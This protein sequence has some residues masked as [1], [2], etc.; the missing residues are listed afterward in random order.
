MFNKTTAKL[1]PRIEKWV[2][3]MQDVD[4]ELVYEPGKDEADPLDFLSRHPLPETGTDSTEKMI[5]QVIEADHAVIIDRIRYETQHDKQLQKLHKRIRAEDWES[6]R[7]DPDITP[8]YSIRQELY[9]ADGLMFRLNRIVIPNCLQHKVIKAAHSLGHLGMTKT[10]QMLR[11]KYWFPM[12]NS[13]VEQIIGQCYECQ[14]TTKDHKQQPI[15]MTPIPEKPWEVIAVDFG[16]PYPDGHYNLVAV[17]KRTRYPEVKTT[18]STAFK[19]TMEKLKEM[20]AAHG[21]PRRLE[22]DNGPPFNSKEFTEF[23]K[24]E[25]LHHHKVTPDH[26]R[27]NGEA[28][29]FMKLLNRAEQ[30]AHLQK[31]NRNII[32]QEML[33]G[34]RSTPHPATNITP[35]EA[36][37]NR[38]VRTKLD[39]QPGKHTQNIKDSI[40]DEND[41]QYK[42]RL[43]QNAENRNTKQ[44]NFVVGDYVLLKQTKKNKWSTAYEPAFYIIYRIDNSSIAARRVT[45]GRDI[46]RDASHFKLVNSVVRNTDDVTMHQDDAESEDDWREGILLQSNPETQPDETSPTQP[47]LSSNKE[48]TSR[49]VFTPPE[50]KP[51]TQTSPEPHT[52]PRRNR[53]RPT[54]LR[55][56]VD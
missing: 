53:Q 8:F 17:D 13:M 24:R 55:D 40:I 48:S 33:T 20:F 12:M 49:S 6:H 16:G 18:H 4:F 29:S 39:H 47:D 35:Y 19:P 50:A 10:K 36:L 25:G 22:S 43:K 2:M 5:K 23:A 46:Y 1:P 41:K 7:K 15:K 56:Y 27:A 51:S 52:R 30:I 54:Y 34:Y 9:E 28:E 3:N 42:E 21:T 31:K 26:A 32:I 14:V 45:D 44:H 38:P 37:M 11:E